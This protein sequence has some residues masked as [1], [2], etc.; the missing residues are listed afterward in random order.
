MRHSRPKFRPS[1]RSMAAFRTTAF[2]STFLTFRAPTAVGQRE[3]LLADD[4]VRDITLSSPRA[5][6]SWARDAGGGSGRVARGGW[7]V[8]VAHEGPS[9]E[10]G[11][12][13]SSV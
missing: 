13:R 7:G 4:Q 1:S 3:P 10:C 6:A 11:D 12:K 8:G 5:R 2:T 9:L